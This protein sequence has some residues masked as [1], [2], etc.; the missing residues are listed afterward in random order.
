MQ[1]VLL[2]HVASLLMDRA[3][4]LTS[5]VTLALVEGS[6]TKQISM[7]K[8]QCEVLVEASE[9]KVFALHEIRDELLKTGYM[10]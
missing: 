3:K 4:Q 8:L 1:T 5:K 2:L 9:S 10:R 6:S 7:F